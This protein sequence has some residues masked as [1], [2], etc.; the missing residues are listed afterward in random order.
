MGTAAYMSPE[1]ALGAP[2]DHRTDLFSLGTV[3]YEMI[4]GRLPFNGRSVTETIDQIRHAQPDPVARYNHGVPPELERI[5]RKL[6]EKDP[7]A[8]YQSARELEVD[9]RNLRRDS[10]SG[11][12]IASSGAGAPQQRRISLAAA[13]ALGLALLLLAG[14][15][16]VYQGR[17]SASATP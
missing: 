9:L 6:H 13:I 17:T 11:E 10:T 16:F 12:R 7:A 3:L 5:L 14:A 4:T 15:A 8:R 1:Q 2:V